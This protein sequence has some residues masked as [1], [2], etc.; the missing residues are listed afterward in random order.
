[1][2][3]ITADQIGSR[4]SADLV[5]A[6]LAGVATIRA[7]ADFERTVGDEVQGVLD[8]ADE[9]VSAVT[10]TL[11]TGHFRVGVG[12]GAVELPLPASPRAGRGPA[13]LAA[14]A[15]VEAAARSGPVAVRYAASPEGRARDA[16][17]ARHTELAEHALVL[18][19]RLLAARSPEGWAVCDLLAAGQA[20]RDA[21][22]ALGVS[23]SA[24]SQRLRRA[25]WAEQ[26]RAAALAIHHL[27]E[28]DGHQLSEADGRTEP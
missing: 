6:L 3:V 26:Q 23:P 1:M 5:P 20:Q 13:F 21:A 27:S 7:R 12:V 10:T 9:V 11:R 19:A 22:A 18:L 24:V 15:A 16:R 2:F 17:R 8:T 25:G 28:A 4:R 14:R